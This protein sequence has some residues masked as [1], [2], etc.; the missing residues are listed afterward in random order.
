MYRILLGCLLVL[1][2][3]CGPRSTA[4][5]LAQLKD[6]DVVKRRQAVRE[7]GARSKEAGRVVPALGDAL[8]DANG[9]VRRD[10]ALALSKFGP[11][12][13]EYVP[14][15]ENALDDDDPGVRRA[16]GIALRKLAPERAGP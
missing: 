16:A 9:Y 4:H 1:A 5:W 11:D 15:L 6:Q 8:H 12:A 2:V 14:V 7:L 3:G 13:R 10:A